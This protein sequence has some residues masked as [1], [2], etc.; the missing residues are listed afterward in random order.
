VDLSHKY[1]PLWNTDY[2][3]AIITGGRG[4]QKSFAVGDFIENL[5]FEK[6]HKILFTRYTLTSAHIS[7]IPEFVEK[8]ELEDHLD[9]FDVNK[10]EIVNK[11]TNSTILFRGIKTS[12]GV[13][14]AS[15]K[16]IQGVSTW[17]LDEAE[18]L[19]D[20]KIFDKIDESIRVTHVKN[21]VI[22]LLNPATK[23]HFIYQRFFEQKGVEP[24]FN[25]IK[26]NVLYIHTD[27]RDNIE[28]LSQK[29]L[30]N[31][32]KSRIARPD[33]FNHV[34]L[35]GWLDK[36]EGVIFT[37]WHIGDFDNSL[38]FGYGL[39]F[40]YS[41]DPDALTRVAIDKDKKIIYLSEEI[42][43]NGLSTTQ[44]SQKLERCLSKPIVAD[45]AEPRLINDLRLKRPGINIIAA[46]KGPD[47]IRSG[48][49]LMQDYTIIISSTSINIIKEFN[50][51]VWN[52]KK[53]GVPV[54][55]YNHAIDG[56]RYNVSK[57]TNYGG[58]ESF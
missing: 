43:Q 55:N 38:D 22:L 18:E 47:S 23:E 20:E 14:T 53:S 32:E 3:Y 46:V 10:T 13:Q 12:S 48:I 2:D 24:G 37:N 6:G 4:S 9:L 40:G 41:V 44:L 7:V 50:N 35:G 31:V 45:S 51:Y 8:I 28:H 36:A 52:D 16:S 11:V 21:R 42:Y 58:Y 33:Y 39:D 25:G 30:N 29:F 5:T 57:F 15:L 19:Q 17:V 34:I 26:D 27:Y 49:K 56:I 54:D 1:K